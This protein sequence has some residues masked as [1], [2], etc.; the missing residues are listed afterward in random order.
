VTQVISMLSIKLNDSSERVGQLPAASDELM[1]DPYRPS[2]GPPESTFVRYRSAR[3]CHT[4]LGELPQ[5]TG[6]GRERN[7]RDHLA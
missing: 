6:K 7:E 5:E 1:D 2:A 4:L 3:D